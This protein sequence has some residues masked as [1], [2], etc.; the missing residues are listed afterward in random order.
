[1]QPIPCFT[2]PQF[3]SHRYLPRGPNGQLR[4]Q[5]WG[6]ADL[7]E[8]Q[9]LFIRLTLDRSSE[10]LNDLSDKDVCLQE[11]TARGAAG[12]DDDRLPSDR[13]KSLAERGAQPTGVQNTQSLSNDQGHVQDRHGDR[14]VRWHGYCLRQSFLFRPEDRHAVPNTAQQETV[15]IQ[16]C[17]RQSRFPMQKDT[18]SLPHTCSR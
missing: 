4:L 18:F 15:P 7:Q 14:S 6:H 16:G 10:T 3:T 12:R 8:R 13:G 2:D 11:A 5:R 1:M 17:R 9:I